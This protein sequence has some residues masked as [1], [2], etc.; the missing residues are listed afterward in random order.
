MV[1]FPHKSFECLIQRKFTL[2]IRSVEQTWWSLR[3]AL[4]KTSHF[5]CSHFKIVHFTVDKENIIVFHGCLLCSKAR[6]QLLYTPSVC[7]LDWCMHMHITRKYNPNSHIET[8]NLFQGYGWL[9]DKILSE[10]GRRQQIQL[11]EIG[12]I[13]DRLGCTLAQLAIG[14]SF[15]P[16]SQ[17]L[18]CRDAR[19]ATSYFMYGCLGHIYSVRPSVYITG[20]SVTSGKRVLLSSKNR[21]TAWSSELINWRLRL[22]PTCIIV[23]DTLY[24]YDVHILL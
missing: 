23:I 4:S 12:L 17:T 16:C 21:E 14:K 15:I 24:I 7:R 19:F 13:A 2:I 5:V 1:S 20:V 18:S 6:T 9:K 3:P 11:R 22:E 10:D 8:V